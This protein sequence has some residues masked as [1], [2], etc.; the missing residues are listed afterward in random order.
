[1]K[2]ALVIIFF[3]FLSTG[4]GQVI[5]TGSLVREMVD[6]ERLANYPDPGYRT[7]QFSSYD[8]RSKS[9]DEPGWFSNSDGFGKEPLPGFIEVLKEKG[10]D[11][12]GEY[13]IC[14]VEGPGAIVRLWTARIYGDIRLY[15]DDI[16]VPFYEGPAQEFF[17]NTYEAL[18][19]DI[20]VEKLGQTFHQNTA[21]YYPIPFAKRCRIEWT[22][23][24]DHL[25]FYH[26]EFRLYENGTQVKTFQLDDFGIYRDDIKQTAMMLESPDKSWST[27]N[28]SYK[29]GF[30]LSV[31][32]G[33]I[34]EV[35]KLL[36]PAAIRNLSIK[37]EAMDQN[38]ALRKNVMNISFDGASTSQVQSPVG[39]FFVTAPGINPYSSLPFTVQEDGWMTCRFVMPFRDSVSIRIKNFGEEEIRIQGNIHSAYYEWKEG[40]SM[41][42][43]A[44]W[45][46]NHDLVASNESP[47]DVPYL[48]ANGRGVVV[49]AAALVMN[50]TSVP[51]SNGNWWGE[52]DEK[53]FVD[54]DAFPSFFGTG[55][56]DYYNYA[57]SSP[58]LFSHGYCG[59]T[60][61]DGPGNRGHVTNFRWHILDPVP[62]SQRIGFYMELLSHGVVPGF[63]YGRIVYHYG[64]PG[65]YDDHIPLMETDVELPLMPEYWTPLKYRGSSNA[66]FYE[67]EE[68]VEVR[69]HVTLK[70]DRRWTEGKMLVWTPEA[71]GDELKFNIPVESDGE[72]LLLF[73]VCKS[74]ESGSFKANIG[75]QKIDFGNSDRVDL[76]ESYGILSRSIRTSRIKLEAGMQ[77]ITL[78][79]Q[80]SDG[81]SIGIDFI[82]TLK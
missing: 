58:E 42:F 13:L 80:S 34:V 2:L 37:V 20:P 41:H 26:V 6:L 33:E 24:I 46:I 79:N 21:G 67:A 9:P 1:M 70:V 55:S 74:P 82:W 71:V 50:P 11:G 29:T 59:Q 49:G 54:R 61:N 44:R 52:G 31:P 19:N 5:T 16:T 73:T 51:T 7:V 60:R 53:I 17:W 47:F 68:V 36:G 38:N 10:E 45:R 12:T 62:F 32:P 81:R 72:Y 78:I 65:I 18:K 15:L 56:E 57:W 27:G 76:Y 3:T 40:S 8:R 4:Y 35:V 22:G 14:D 77:T 75:N 64:I 25:H 30:N 69:D 48:L 43:R 28:G 39:D 23:N 66:D 63:S